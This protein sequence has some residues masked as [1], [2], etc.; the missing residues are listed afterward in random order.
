MKC[1]K[2]GKEDSVTKHWDKIGFCRN[3]NI[4]FDLVDD[5]FYYRCPNDRGS[6]VPRVTFKNPTMVCPEC[7]SEYRPPKD[8]LGKIISQDL[9]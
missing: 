7:K 2:C 8:N 9:G 4:S 3:C 1:P 6:L 5:R